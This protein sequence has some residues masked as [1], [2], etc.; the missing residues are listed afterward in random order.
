M[1]AAHDA[2]EHEDLPRLR[3]LLDGGVDIEEVDGGQTL[4]Q[5]AIDVEI[6]G[7]TQTGEPL[8]VDVTAYLL[9]RGADPGAGS[10]LHHARLRGHWLAVALIEAQDGRQ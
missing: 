4:L 2:V 5:H 9:A 7:H 6:D 8:H 3:E 1:T 10:A